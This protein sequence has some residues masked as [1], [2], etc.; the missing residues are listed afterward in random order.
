MTE[1]QLLSEDDYMNAIDEYGEDSFTAMIGAEAI[2]EILASMDLEKSAGQLRTDLAETSS[3]LKSKKL[4]KRLKVVEAFL[5]SGN[6]PEWM[7]MKTIPVI[8][9]GS[10]SIGS[11]GWWPV[12]HI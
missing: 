9:A 10:A 4:A 6:R 3:E 1:Y 5:E 12:C 11:A 8:S 2:H 7:I